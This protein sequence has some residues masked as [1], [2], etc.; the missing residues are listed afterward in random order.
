MIVRIKK[1]DERLKIKEGEHYNAE[2]YS[3]DS[4]K[5][6]LISRIPDGYDPECTQYLHEVEKISS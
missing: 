1:T 3:L 2:F 4:G 5:V 6:I